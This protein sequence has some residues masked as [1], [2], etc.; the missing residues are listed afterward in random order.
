MRKCCALKAARTALATTTEYP[1]VLPSLDK[2]YQFVAS[3]SLI[4]ERQAQTQHFGGNDPGLSEGRKS[5]RQ[6][7]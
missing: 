6:A 7:G 2:R 1:E 4:I 3:D 5:L